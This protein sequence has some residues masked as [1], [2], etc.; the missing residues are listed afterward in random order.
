MAG[1]DFPMQQGSPVMASNSGTVVLARELFY[2]GNCVVLGHGQHFFPIYMHLSKIQVR[3][4]Q[5]VQKRERLGLS[6]G[7]GRVT[8]PHL[9][10]G[11]RWG[12]MLTPPSCS[13]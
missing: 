13:H 10:M 5:K 9:H 11:V 6:G 8:G 4:G 3:Q 7:T 12:A 1:T 2:E